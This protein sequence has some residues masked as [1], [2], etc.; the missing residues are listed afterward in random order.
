MNISSFAKYAAVVTVG[1]GLLAACSSNGGSSLAPTGGSSAGADASHPTKAIMVNGV[2][3]TAARPSMLRA[4]PVSP[5]RRKHHKKKPD[6]YI[7]DFSNSDVFEFD[8]PKSDSSIGTITGVSNA[9]GECTKN[10]KNTF[11]VTATGSSQIDEFKVGGSTPINTLSTESEGQPAGCGIDPTTGN[12]AATIITNGD[13]VVFANAS[14]T[15]TT[16]ASGLTEAFFA[17]YDKSGNLFVDGFGN[18]GV[19][20]VELV[21]GGSSFK[22]ITPSNTIEFPGNIQWDGTYVT[23][24]DQEGFAIYQYTV[25]GSTATLKGT[26]SYQGASDCDQTWIAKSVFYCPD[27][28]AANAKVYKYPAGGEPVATLTASF[29]EPIGAVQVTK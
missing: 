3:T 4:V 25:S 19:G 13:V 2:L 15:G 1:A 6:Q 22:P 16:Y 9:Q 29:A 12:L 24:N 21:K 23:V 5:D 17:T 7:S 27:A 20:I 14:G 28:G 26:V 18:A 10:G 8:Y 11:W